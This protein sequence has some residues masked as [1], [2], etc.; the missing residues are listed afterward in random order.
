MAVT[1]DP[2]EPDGRGPGYWKAEPLPVFLQGD[3]Y[4]VLSREMTA[5]VSG[6]IP[7]RSFLISGH[8]GAGKTTLVERVARDVGLAKIVTF[9]RGGDAGAGPRRPLL[10]KLYGPSLVQDE[11]PAPAA[12]TP[13]PTP[14]PMPADGA[15]AAA[16][17]AV[18]AV[19]AARDVASLG[20]SQS[21]PPERP[22]GTPHKTLVQIGIALY[23]ALAE[24]AATSLRLH[25]RA[26]HDRRAGD[27]L[28]F[29]AQFS[30]ELDR[31]ADAAAL[32]Q[33]WRRAGRLEE[34]V[35]WPSG[36]DVP[37]PGGPPPDQG[38]R[39]IV[40]IATAAQAFQV[41]TGAVTYSR[42]E[43][44][45]A[46]ASSQATTGGALDLTR[47]IN[48]LASIA[49]G[50]GAGALAASTG[51]SSGLALGAAL[52]AGLLGLGAFSWSDTRSQKSNQALDYT[53]I[54][55][56]SA[57]TL[58]QDLPLVIRRVRAAGL[59]PVF[60]VDELD[61]VP[62]AAV[63]IGQM[64]DRLKG[65]VTD[66]GFFCFVTDRDTLEQIEAK[67]RREGYPVEHTYFSERLL[68]AYSPRDVIGHLREV[69]RAPD[70]SDK[71]VRDAVALETLLHARPNF[72]EVTR[73][74]ARLDDAA[75]APP[76]TARG[77]L[78]RQL[79]AA[80][81]LAIDAILQGPE[82]GGRIKADPGFLQF[83][84]DTLYWPVS[85]WKRGEPGFGFDR[86][87][88]KTRLEERLAQRPAGAAAERLSLDD[89]FE[90]HD[91]DTLLQQL[92]ALMDQL[93]RFN[94][95][96]SILARDAFW[97]ETSAG[98]IPSLPGGEPG[99][100][101]FQRTGWYTWLYDVTGRRVGDPLE[102]L[103]PD[104]ISNERL[105]QIDAAVATA[106]SFFRLLD[107]FDVTFD[108]VV[109][110]G[111]LPSALTKLDFDLVLGRL[112]MAADRNR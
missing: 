32:R 64:I 14:T 97:S 40:A 15:T 33:I 7:G 75:L 102:G 9:R 87:S 42:T 85:C 17:A 94:G 28:E 109:D 84:I 62:N 24:E 78:R 47:T 60:V 8:R 68:I 4:R 1:L 2:I 11:P 63:T 80:F 79:A 45:T 61:K 90:E 29:A 16:V 81:Q 106:E 110:S 88:L 91:L 34:G 100:A 43:K 73:A 53:F 25:T 67:I 22:V 5:Y 30:L 13:T 111:L 92:T 99:M 77:A 89:L 36:L 21:A 38:V 50:G 82:L 70:A 35:L 58:E 108:Q 112:K 93:T 56:N 12:P 104:Q 57:Q 98:L 71:I 103:D 19:A 41:C 72:V 10:V 48:K 26:A 107:A 27:Q 52:G 23:R 96:R 86:Q 69:L 44:N 6:Q 18:A 76:A 105:A 46:D 3:A 54:R 59:N 95:L 37:G 66:F 55:D 74:L 65:L 39:E 49:V 83:A 31:P 101:A 20:A 51:A